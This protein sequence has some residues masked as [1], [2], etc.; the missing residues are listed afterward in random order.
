VGILVAAS[1]TAAAIVYGFMKKTEHNI[2]AYDLEGG[3]SDVSRQAIGNGI[4]L[5]MFS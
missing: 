4:F 2:L 3:T 5:P 1:T